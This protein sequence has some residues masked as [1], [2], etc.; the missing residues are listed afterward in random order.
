MFELNDI[1]NT[2]VVTPM[3]ITTTRGTRQYRQPVTLDKLSSSIVDISPRCPSS[4]PFHVTTQRGKA[5][6]NAHSPPG[7]RKRA[8]QN[9]I[10]L[11]LA[12]AM[13]TC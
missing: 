10:S 8:A 1:P 9:H 3:C 12:T 4:L 2:E 5:K 7:K 6:F 13:T 11:Q